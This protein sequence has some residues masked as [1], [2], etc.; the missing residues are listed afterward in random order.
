[1]WRAAVE[2]SEL[3]KMGDRLKHN[4][5]RLSTRILWDTVTADLPILLATAQEMIERLEEPAPAE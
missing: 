4:Y 5:H 1:L 3:I 2:W